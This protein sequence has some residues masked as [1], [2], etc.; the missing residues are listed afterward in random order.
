MKIIR[1]IVS[2]SVHT[3]K[4]IPILSL[5]EHDI[6]LISLMKKRHK[7]NASQERKPNKI[8]PIPLEDLPI[9]KQWESLLEPEIRVRIKHGP[10]AGSIGVVKSI[11]GTCADVEVDE[12]DTRGKH[13]VLSAEKTWLEPSLA[14]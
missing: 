9:I 8:T 7:N 1:S 6:L 2:R 3:L 5:N 4:Q 10:D 14:I 12:L 11:L 13:L